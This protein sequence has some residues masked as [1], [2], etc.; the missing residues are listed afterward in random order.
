M[1][2]SSRLTVLDLEPGPASKHGRVALVPAMMWR[3]VVRDKRSD[4]SPHVQM[5]SSL[6]NLMVIA[7]Y[8]TTR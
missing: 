3:S 4:M 7:Q 1:A 5:K 8:P 6:S 2:V